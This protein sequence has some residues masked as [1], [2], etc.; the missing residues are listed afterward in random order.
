MY[1]AGEKSFSPA[2]LLKSFHN[3]KELSADMPHTEKHFGT[4]RWAEGFL[5][6]YEKSRKP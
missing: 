2:P 1:D 4:R 6:I 5:H 3:E